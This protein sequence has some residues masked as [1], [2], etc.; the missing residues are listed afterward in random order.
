VRGGGGGAGH[1]KTLREGHDFAHLY[2]ALSIAS[3]HELPDAS[4]RDT[5]TGWRRQLHAM[6]ETGFEEAKT[7]A[8]VVRVLKALGL[9]V[10]TGIGGTGLVANLKVGRAA[11]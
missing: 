11:A 9:E 2:R 4:L 1:A 10:H 8:F 3:R 7:S 6:P 5:L